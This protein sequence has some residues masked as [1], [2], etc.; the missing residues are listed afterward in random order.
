MDE[1]KN[2]DSRRVRFGLFE[3]DLKS[4]ELRRSGIRVCLQRQPFKVLATLL[5]QPGTIVSREDLQRQLWGAGTNVDFDHSLGI[6]VN[7][8]REALGDSADNPR[9]IET[10][11]KRGYRFIAPVTFPAAFVDPD[12]A[13]LRRW[14]RQWC[15]PYTPHVITAVLACICAALTTTLLVRTP[16][17]RPYHVSEITHSGMVMTNDVDLESFSSSASD[18]TRIYFSMLKN[19]TP[20][21]AEALATNGEIRDF[22]LPSE[23]IGAPLI[24]ALSPDGSNLVLRSHA[25]AQPEQSL[26]IVPT[27]GGDARRVPNVLAHD[28]T[29]M[30][31]GERLLVAS[32]NTLTVMNSDGSD[33]HPL[34]TVP[35]RAFWMRWSPDGKRLRF[36]LR[37][38]KRQTSALWE[39]TVDGFHVQ[40]LL[41]DW[42]HPASEC[43]GSWTSDGEYFVF[44]AWHSGHSEI[45]ARREH[46]LYLRDSQPH[47]IIGGPL[48]YEAPIAFPR[49]H[50]IYF[51][52]ANVRIE[53]L[54]ALSN[55]SAFIPLDENLSSAAFAGYSHDGRW[56]AWLNAS[57]GSLWRSRID[58]S[59]RIELTKPPLRIFS[60]RWSPDDKHLALMAEAPGKPWKIYVID[61]DGGKLVPVLNE[62]RNEA[63]PDWSVDGQT[64]VFGRLP[65]RMDNIRPKAIYLLNLQTH[66][67]SEI[68]GSA[69]LFS[70]RFSPNGRYVAAMTLDQRKLLLFERL[71]GRWTTLTMHNVG[72]PTWSHDSRYLYFQDF[73]EPGKPIYRITIPAGKPEL[74]TSISK[75][76]PIAAADYRLI[77][78]GPGDLPIVSARTSTVNLYKVDLDEH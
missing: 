16:T 32:G 58:G 24:G 63:D 73:I 74:V 7:K 57:D 47:E 3:V 54:R 18:G 72:D 46:P 48:S 45:W 15:P 14:S 44:Q 38:S 62:D 50:Q 61:A 8:L 19:G 28:A 39:A 49:S 25:E 34:L 2:K 43:C 67:L 75:L 6:A 64:I 68:P 42:S 53:L 9:F 36:T 5:E 78:L 1:L 56:V 55:F 21:L 70:P 71:T 37:D 69:D 22:H 29:W 10:L 41:P 4:W 23:E 51:I 26:W 11:A 33:A 76:N 31:D 30:P 60:M 65:D 66:K 12:S 40:P 27:L 17:H 35:G 77:G 20:A 13:N 59:E 52:G